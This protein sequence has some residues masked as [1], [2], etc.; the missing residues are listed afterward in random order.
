MD[1]SYLTTARLYK[2]PP[3]IRSRACAAYHA[4]GGFPVRGPQNMFDMNY[5]CGNWCT[6]R[7][8]QFA[9]LYVGVGGG[10]LL[11]LP[12]SAGVPAA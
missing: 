7:S 8:R 6:A 4:G 12:I 2:K 1:T 9:V 11:R 5:G 3:P 10:R